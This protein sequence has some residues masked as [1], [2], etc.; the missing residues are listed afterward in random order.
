MAFTPPPP[1]PQRGDRTTFSGR[2]DAFL[3]WMANLVGELGVFLA[4]LTRLAAGGTFSTPYRFS[5]SAS[6][7][8]SGGEVQYPGAGSSLYVDTT[9][10][11]NK[12]VSALLASLTAGS[13]NAIKGSI[14]LVQVNDPT[15]Y[16][17][18][19]V[20]SYAAVASYATFTVARI[21]GGAA[22]AIDEGADVVMFF[23]RNGDKGDNGTVPYL[24]ITD[25]K[26]GGTP[27]G[28]AVQGVQTRTLNTLQVNEITGASISGNNIT[29][30][31]GTYEVDIR[32]PGA[33]RSHVASLYNVTDAVTALQGSSVL[34][35]P[36]GSGVQVSSDSLIRG[37]LVLTAQKTLNVRH[38]FVT[39]GGTSSALG[40]TVSGAGLAVYTDVIIKK[41]L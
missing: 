9:D 7:F 16:M 34:N 22:N 17:V 1:V 35:A 30:P 39:A 32:V 15:K 2:V 12:S 31:A 25:T 8:G 40:D 6:G 24:R 10:S 41:V 4:S 26:A 38:Y 33:E 3:V 27:G 18:F 13:L 29:L 23:Q 28:V 5:Y 36:G 11:S 20:S 19:N 21:D 14:R 37:R